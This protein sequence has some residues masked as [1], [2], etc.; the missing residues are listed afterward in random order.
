MLNRARSLLE[1]KGWA[2]HD[3]APSASA[4]RNYAAGNMVALALPAISVSTGTARLVVPQSRTTVLNRESVLP[5]SAFSSLPAAS[6]FPCG[7]CPVL[8]K[9]APDSSLRA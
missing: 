1:K 5:T 6:E 9:P 8:L 3:L 4:E 7:R 2:V